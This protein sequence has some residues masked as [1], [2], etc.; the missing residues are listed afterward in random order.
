MNPNEWVQ[1]ISPKSLLQD[2]TKKDTFTTNDKYAVHDNQKIRDG[3]VN[4][5]LTNIDQKPSGVIY[6]DK[7][8]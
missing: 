1:S 7:K 4:N 6:N 2:F 3:Y 8:I 5:V